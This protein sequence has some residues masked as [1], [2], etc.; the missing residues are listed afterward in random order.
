MCF[1][2]HFFF[3]HSTCLL[4]IVALYYDNFCY[5]KIIKRLVLEKTCEMIL[6][7]ETYKMG[8]NFTDSAKLVHKFH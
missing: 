8:S 6:T 3:F 4:V 2:I 7:L 5:D 1:H